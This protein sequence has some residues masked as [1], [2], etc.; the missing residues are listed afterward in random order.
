MIVQAIRSAIFYLF[1]FIITLVLAIIASIGALIPPWSKNISRA[2]ANFWAKTIRFLLFLIVGIK[3]KITGLENLPDTPC[4]VA[5]KHQ[6]DLDTIALYPKLGNPSFIAKIELFKIPFLGTV[7]RA[8][9]TISVDR[10]KKSAALRDLIE[11]GRN[12]IENGQ[13]IFIFPEGTRK[14]PLAPPNFR[15]GTA[16]LYEELNVPVVP[17]ALNSGLFWGRNSLVLWPGTARIEILPPIPPGLS[18]NEMHEKMIEAIDE[19]SRKLVLQ[20]VDEGLTRPI[21]P[22]FRERIEKSR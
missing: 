1:F 19:N 22:D 7:I 4:I 12:R 2:I 10:K 17:I 6:S 14:P 15:F 9:G 16:K 18:A 13:N 8:I 21:D 3:T 11:Q 5:S 20:A